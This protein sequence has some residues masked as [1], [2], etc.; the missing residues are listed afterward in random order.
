MIDNDMEN[1]SKMQSLME[2]VSKMKELQGQGL[3]GEDHED[4][5]G[6]AL[7]VHESHVEPLDH[8]EVEKLEE[9]GH[10]DLDND[11]EKG[12]S[13]EHKEMVMDE[14]PSEESLSPLELHPG[15]LQ[16]LQQHMSS[17]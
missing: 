5:K 4:P 2:L 7:E 16:L 1:K 17:K 14:E 11:D 3:K 10:E 9:A 6:L 15:L 13:P 12:E 8:D